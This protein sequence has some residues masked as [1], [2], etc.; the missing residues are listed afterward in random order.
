MCSISGFTWEDENLIKKMNK[1]LSYRGPDDSGIYIDKNISLGHNRLSI[2]D[3]SKAGHQPMKNEEGNLWIVYNGEV[4]NYKEIR[5]K[6]ELKGYNFNSNTDTEVILASYEEFGKRCLNLFNGMFAFAIW[7]SDK[8][9]LFLAR[10]RIG[11]KPLYFMIF[12]KNLIFSSEIKA[13]LQ[14]DFEK[15]IDLQ[16]L[17]NYLTYRFIPSNKTII[18]GIYKL[19]PA[20]YAIFKNGTLIIKKY[21]DLKWNVSNK[22]IEYYVRRLNKLLIESVNKRL[23]SDVPLG[24]F[25]SGGIDSSL[26]VAINTIL[27]KDEVKTFTV[28]F[29][30]KSDEFKYARKVSEYL[31]TNHYEL[32]LDYKTITRSLPK[33]IWH[34]DEL[35]SDITMVPLYFLS[36]FARK[37]VIVVNTGEGSDELFSGYYPYIIASKI[38][39]PIPKLLR[40][41]IYLWYYSPFKKRFRKSLLKN[42]FYKDFLLNQYLFYRQ[43]DNSPKYFLNKILFFDIKNELPNWQLP[44][45]DRMTMAHSM[46]ARVPFLDHNIVEFSTKIPIKFKQPNL[47][48]KYLLKK[49]ALNYLPRDIVL[50]KKQGFTTPLYDWIKENLEGVAESLFWTHKK[51]FLNYELINRLI[52]KH[53]RSIKPRLFQIYSFQLL[54]LI[55]FE[56]W[57]EIF[58]NGVNLSKIEK[59]LMI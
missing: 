23:I 11:I 22:S 56:I 7:D 37:K 34:M 42:K 47:L 16:S 12:D 8:K 6:L 55:F 31:S 18:Q 49:L 53:K 1:I 58:L 29:D 36:K 30:H 54:M 4:Y 10:D 25:L 24:A 2:I 3:L 50:R 41:K 40:K 5:K 15:L 48:G 59:L 52:L 14:Y 17:N 35:N 39:T 28:G 9:E 57:Y 20:H 26:I 27:R 51:P 45:V 33:I 32:V 19:L 13:I 38:F 46:E 43:S 44:R 21:W